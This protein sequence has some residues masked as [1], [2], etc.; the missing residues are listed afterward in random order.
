MTYAMWRADKGFRVGTTRT[1]PDSPGNVVSG[2]GLR[3]MQE[4][5][6]AAW[7]VSTHDSRVGGTRR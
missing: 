7:I 3:A 6:D 5:A 2:V 4:N 1:H